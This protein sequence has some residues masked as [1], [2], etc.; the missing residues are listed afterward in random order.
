LNFLPASASKK[1]PRE[2]LLPTVLTKS[3]KSNR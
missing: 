1:S 2:K 3:S